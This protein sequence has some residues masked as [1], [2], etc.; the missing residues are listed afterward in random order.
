MTFYPS[1]KTFL[2]FTYPFLQCV[3]FCYKTRT[4]PVITR[5][6]LKFDYKTEK[7]TRREKNGKEWKKK[8][9]KGKERKKVVI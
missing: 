9:K 3:S 5:V 8:E 4:T 2:P 7:E 6:W 1:K